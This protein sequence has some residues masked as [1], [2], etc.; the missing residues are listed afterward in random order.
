MCAEVIH[1]HLCKVGEY[2][3]VGL[4]TA[5]S[6]AFL[7]QGLFPTLPEVGESK[8]T[9]N[10]ATRSTR[11]GERRAEQAEGSPFTLRTSL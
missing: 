2:E 7:L 11:C 10:T 8:A 9:G 5:A 3:V 1:W 4:F 6:H